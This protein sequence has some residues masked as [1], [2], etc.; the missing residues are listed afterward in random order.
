MAAVIE[1]VICGYWG[2]T[3]IIYEAERLLR[4]DFWRSRRP[5]GQIRHKQLVK[6]NETLHVR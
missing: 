5:P 6:L 4:V 2:Q 3:T 1:D